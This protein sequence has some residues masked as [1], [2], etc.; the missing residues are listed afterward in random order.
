MEDIHWFPN[1][2]ISKGNNE[3]KAPKQQQV[4][5]SYI[6]HVSVCNELKFR[7]LSQG[8]TSA[9]AGA[10]TAVGDAASWVPGFCSK[11][12]MKMSCSPQVRIE[13]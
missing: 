7:K 13:C 9:T 12:F 10:G 5:A 4:L 1:L 3:A 11:H 2:I 8:T 6:Q